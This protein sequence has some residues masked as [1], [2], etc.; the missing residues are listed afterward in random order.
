MQPQI[1]GQWRGLA[2][3]NGLFGSS[4]LPPTWIERAKIFRCE[5]P[6]LT[7]Y[8][9][10]LRA[11]VLAGEDHTPFAHEILALTAGTRGPFDSVIALSNWQRQKTNE[12]KDRRSRGLRLP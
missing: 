11:C 9:Q 4:Y 2:C 12:A 6:V 1:P 3:K 5:D 8:Q 7:G 10:R